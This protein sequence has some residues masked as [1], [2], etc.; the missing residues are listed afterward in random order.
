M[1]VVGEKARLWERRGRHDVIAA[2]GFHDVGY[3]TNYHS[4]HPT[5]AEYLANL[6]WESGVAEAVQ[7]E[8]SGVRDL[9]RLFGRYPSAWATPGSSWGPQIPAAMREVGVPATVY[10]QVRAGESGACWFAGEFCY[11]DFIYFPGGEDA[12]A[13]DTTF[14]AAL[15]KLLEEVATEQRR[16]RACLGLFVAHPTRLRYTEFWDSLNFN[17]GQNTLASNYRFAPRRTDEQYQTS[18]RNLRRLM[19]ALR[20]LPGVEIAGTSTITQ[21]FAGE[22]YPVSLAQTREL[23]QIVLDQG[24]MGTEH[25]LASPAQT[26]DL[27][28]RAVLHRAHSGMPAYLPLRTVLGPAESPP[29]LTAPLSVPGDAALAACQTLLTHIAKQG[30]LPTA[31]EVAGAHVGPGALVRGIAA[32]LL[33]AESHPSQAC[34]SPGVE[35]PPTAQKLAQEGIYEMLPGWTP[36]APNLRL[37]LLALHVRLQSWSLKPAVLAS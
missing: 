24:M 4:I 29:E 27:M 26:L 20:N 16:G 34:F 10:A 9:A 15:P 13:D 23:A 31:L 7:Q 22:N 28:A 36:H 2:V 35:E 12:Y 8:G 3:H 5:I 19:L 18:L 37:D 32:F 33:E 6:G 21:H 25:W 30:H 1:F 14:E 11:A 17:R